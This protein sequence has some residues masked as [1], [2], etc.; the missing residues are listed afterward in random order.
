[1]VYDKP[2]IE[3]QEFKNVPMYLMKMLDSLC[4]RYGY[5]IFPIIKQKLMDNES[6]KEKDLERFSQ[7]T[8][9]PRGWLESVKQQLP[10]DMSGE[11]LPW[12]TYSSVEF[13]E[14]VIS[15][16]TRVFEFGCGN[17]TLWWQKRVFQVISVDHDLEWVNK[18]KPNIK[19]PHY[20]FHK[21]SEFNSSEK[22]QLIYQEYLDSQPRVDFDYDKSK[23]TRRGLNDVDFIGYAESILEQPGLFDCIVI[24]GMARRL[25]T[26]FAVKKLSDKGIIVFDNSNRSDY[27]EGYQYLV[28]QGFYQIRLSGTVPGASFPS[29]TSIFIKTIESIPKI[30]FKKPLFDI[31]EY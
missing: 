23:I 15:Q 30:V 18:I 22:G 1:V 31:P 20:L 12:W 8:L 6:T 4:S 13:M 21:G 24:D 25:C 10:V 29:C 17:S 14:T 11:A 3:D 9:K 19:R 27:L 7:L 5:P 26:Y 16:H 2:D 28:D